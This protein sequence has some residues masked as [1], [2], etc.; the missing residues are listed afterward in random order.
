[1]SFAADSLLPFTLVCVGVLLIAIWLFRFAE[2]YDSIGKGGIDIGPPTVEP[3]IPAEMSEIQQMANA[4]AALRKKRGD[5]RPS[6][7][8]TLAT[9]EHD[10]SLLLGAATARMVVP[11]S[12]PSN[13]CEHAG[14]YTGGYVRDRHMHAQAHSPA[15]SSGKS[16][17]AGGNAPSPRGS[18]TGRV[19]SGSGESP[20][21]DH[22]SP[23]LE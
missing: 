3:D 5:P 12:A 22:S 10:L 11:A 7:P 9:V 13:R 16:E 1:V 2:L 20:H 8:T 4:I 14:E 17:Q 21:P 18:Q 15:T 23:D 6:T 19:P